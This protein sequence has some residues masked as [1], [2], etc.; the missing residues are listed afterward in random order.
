M[1]EHPTIDKRVHILTDT[2]EILCGQPGGNR[3]SF[4]K[5]RLRKLVTCKKCLRMVKEAA[6]ER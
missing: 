5:G 1:V 6:R 3:T 2:L 4:Y